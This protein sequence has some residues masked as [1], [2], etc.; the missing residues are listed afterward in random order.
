MS[1]RRRSKSKRKV[2]SS[3]DKWKNKVWVELKAPMYIG[4]Q[5]I[6]HTPAAEPEMA[7]GRTVKVQ[8]PKLTGNF[9]D[10]QKIVTLKVSEVN[11][12][13]GQTDFIG[14][15][16]SRENMRSVVRNHRSRIDGIYNIKFTDDTRIRMTVFCV[17][18]IRAKTSEKKIIRKIISEAVDEAVKDLTFPAFVNKVLDGSIV[19]YVKEKVVDYFPVKTLEI[20]KIKVL[21]L[22]KK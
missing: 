5:V 21:R 1:A 7:I 12:T 15:E 8:Q 20:S 19:E 3:T 6:G 22:S 11:G 10:F 4:D 17:T 14:Y 2:L 13:I 9:K 18:P 16:L